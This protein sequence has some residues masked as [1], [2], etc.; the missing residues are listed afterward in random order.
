MTVNSNKILLPLPDGWI[1]A[2]FVRRVKRFSVELDLNGKRFWAHTNNSGAMLGLLRRGAPVV[3]SPKAGGNKKYLWT[4]E[5][6][7]AGTQNN[8]VWVGVNTLTPNRLLKAAFKENLLEFAQGY[9]QLQ[10][11]KKTMNSR[12]DGYFTGSGRAPLWVE[13]KSVTLVEDGVAAFP[14]AVSER[15]QKHIKALMEIIKKGERGAMFF[16][17]QRPDGQCFA[18]ADYI[19]PLYSRYF[20]EAVQY[21]VEA[22]AYE[23]RLLPEGIA[24]GKQLKLK[25]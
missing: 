1:Y 25:A 2:N 13:C 19:D 16:L 23:A 11:E 22:Y 17:V 9:E 12:L 10:T 18:P 5:R 14:D 4:L 3:L 8:G 20:Y 6:I 24:L 7:W 15:A 21:G